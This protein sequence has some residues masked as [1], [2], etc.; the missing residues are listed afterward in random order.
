MQWFRQK[1]NAFF[2]DWFDLFMEL[3][4]VFFVIWAIPCRCCFNFCCLFV[5]VLS[6]MFMRLLFYNV[7]DNS[8]LKNSFLIFLFLFIHKVLYFVGFVNCDKC[9]L[10][11]S[12]SNCSQYF[13]KFFLGFRSVV[14]SQCKYA[15][16]LF[17]FS[18]C[19][20]SDSIKWLLVEIRC[21]LNHNFIYF[22]RCVLILVEC[23]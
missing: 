19:F 2:V 7:S 10:M 14:L 23:S 11:C 16:I 18:S 9:K 3:E 17:F 6:V 12:L 5:V 1:S 20:Q 22:S 13:T 4:L 21:T 8:T 15:F